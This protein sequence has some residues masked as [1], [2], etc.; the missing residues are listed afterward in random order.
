MRRVSLVEM[1]RT[2]GTGV[3]GE[4]GDPPD[5]LRTSRGMV[6]PR[7]RTGGDSG[8]SQTR[9]PWMDSAGMLPVGDPTAGV[10][11]AQP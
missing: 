6:A 7:N 10:A 9:R 3:F 4:A 1:R 2:A 8:Q 11:L 5:R